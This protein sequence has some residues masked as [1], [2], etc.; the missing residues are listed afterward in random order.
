MRSSRNVS[1]IAVGLA[2]IATG[3]KA[4]DDSDDGKPGSA[5]EPEVSELAQLEQ[6]IAGLKIDLKRTFPK[7]ADGV[8]DCGK[9]ADCF[10]V[11]AHRCEPAELEH[12][13]EEVGY[14]T[15]KKVRAR[16][17]I[18]GGSG[19]ECKVLRLVLERDMELPPKARDALIKQGKTAAEID[20][21]RTEALAILFAHTP[22]QMVCPFTKPRAI[23][24]ALAI[25]TNDYTD[26]FFREPCHEPIATDGWPADFVPAAAAAPAEPAAPAVP[27]APAAPAP[28]AEG[29][30]PA[31]Q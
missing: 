1:F 13:I 12:G 17:R 25:T 27:A 28:P 30:A 3:C 7:R 21:M 6:R 26:R 16:Y 5:A 9:D 31:A 20:A 15:T 11:M 24:L 4:C 18:A 8:V 22:S 29:K 2:L 10:V 23:T 14:V 19:D